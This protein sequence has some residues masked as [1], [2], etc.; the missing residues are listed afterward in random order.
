MAI[1]WKLF[2]KEILDAI[3]QMHSGKF[4]KQP[5]GRGTCSMGELALL[6]VGENGVSSAITEKGLLT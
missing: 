6:C 5:A 4:C 3:S 1:E 2:N